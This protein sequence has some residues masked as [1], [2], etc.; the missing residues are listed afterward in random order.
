MKRILAAALALSL[1]AAMFT[2]CG[3]DSS[4]SSA[5]E[6]TTTTTAAASSEASSEEASSEEASSEEAS[7]E[8]ASSEDASSEDASSEGEGEQPVDISEAAK[9][10]ANYDNALVTFSADTDVDA[11]VKDMQEGFASIKAAVG[12]VEAGKDDKGKDY[13]LEKFNKVWGAKGEV[14]GIDATYDSDYVKK[15]LADDTADLQYISGDESRCKYSVEE[16]AGI[17]MLKIEILDK[18]A[19]GVNYLIP[20]PQFKLAEIFKGH[21]D[22]LPKVN[23]VKMDI[24]QKAVGEFTA[25]DGSSALVPGNLMGTLAVQAQKDGSMT[26][27]QNDFAAADWVSEWVYVEASSKELLVWGTSDYSNTTDEQYVTIMRWGIPNDACL[28]IADIAFYDA[29]GNP[30]KF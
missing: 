23:V 13:D 21:E 25:E 10:L 4:S 9:L 2:A 17:P 24:I 22:L 19:D 14:Y 26:W 3:D 30:I 28:Y 11:I 5:A 8:E 7:S 29:D 20:K 27:D 18:Y 16:V 12:Y 15:V 1:S 6:T